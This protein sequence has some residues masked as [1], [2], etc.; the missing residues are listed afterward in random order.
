MES[1]GTLPAQPDL[2]KRLT[3]LRQ[4]WLPSGLRRPL[5]LAA[6]AMLSSSLHLLFFCATTGLTWLHDLWPRF[7]PY[8]SRAAPALKSPCACERPVA[9]AP[10][11]G[12]GSV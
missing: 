9:S 11:S 3:R 12:T 8:H 4:L 1:K 6:V 10:H 7:V 2:D 5:A